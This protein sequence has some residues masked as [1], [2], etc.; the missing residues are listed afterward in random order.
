MAAK[1]T[2]DLRFTGQASEVLMGA[3][4][5]DTIPIKR[6]ELKLQSGFSSF[7]ADRDFGDGGIVNLPRKWVEQHDLVPQCLPAIKIRGASME[8]MLFEDDGVVTNI[9]DTKPQNNALFAINFDGEAV[10]KKMVCA[11]TDWWLHSFNQDPRWRRV[12]CR[13]G[14]CIVIEKVR[15]SKRKKLDR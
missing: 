6:V 11:G 8:P 13:D 10:V 15:P 2:C 4:L 5:I 14:E 3:P 1:T 12:A 7:D 9:A